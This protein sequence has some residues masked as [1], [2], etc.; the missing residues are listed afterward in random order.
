MR[1]R[2]PP[3]PPMRIRE[4]LFIDNFIS[5]ITAHL[6][7]LRTHQVGG[8]RRVKP[9]PATTPRPRA[10]GITERWGSQE[11]PGPCHGPDRWVQIPHAPPIQRVRSVEAWHSCLAHRG[12]GLNS[13]RIHQWL[14]QRFL[15]ESF[16]PSDHTAC[17]QA[18]NSPLSCASRSRPRRI[19][20]QCSAEDRCLS[21]LGPIV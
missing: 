6:E 20:M 18:S 8:I 3:S 12:T 9:S 13:R 7:R 19:R 10:G 21:H 1:V 2:V 4:V 5:K 14:E 11:S 17:R 16:S 15:S